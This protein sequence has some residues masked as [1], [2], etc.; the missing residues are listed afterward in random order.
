[1]ELA[2]SI[3]AAN[4]R[5]AKTM[6]SG[7][8]VDEAPAKRQ[9]SEDYDF[10][11]AEESRPLSGLLALDKFIKSMRMTIDKSLYIDFASMSKERLDQLQV[12]GVGSATQKRLSTSTV[13]VTSASEADVKILTHDYESISSGFLYSYIKLLSESAFPNA[14]DRVK[15]RLAWWQWLTDFFGQNKA[16]TVKFIHAFMLKHHAAPFWM[17]VTEERCSMLAIQARDTCPVHTPSTI[18]DSGSSRNREKKNSRD[19]KQS[20]SRVFP[21]P[22]TL[23]IHGGVTFTA[24]QTAKLVQWRSRFAG[25]CQSR[26][27]KEY[28]CSREKRGMACKWKH[29]CAWCHSPTCKATCAQAE[30]L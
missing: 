5:Y 18:H 24:S 4:A 7:A 13:L 20:P 25:Y 12:L 11:D 22:G 8:T 9:R 30:K 27:T 21:G 15:D 23:T 16:A 14:M 17:P 2:K 10:D 1:M 28:S 19:K 3:A 26:M 29:E 6:A